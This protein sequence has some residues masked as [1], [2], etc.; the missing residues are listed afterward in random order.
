[1]KNGVFV[2]GTDTEVG[3][4]VVA[5]GLALVLKEAGVNVGVMKPVA[6]GC[7]E[8]GKT[9]ISP[10][11]VFLMEAAEN[12]FASLSSPYR[13]KESLAPSVA[14]ELENIEID[15]SRILFAYRELRKNY[16]IVE[17]AGGLFAPI[18][19]DFF[20][21]DLI[22][23]M[24]LSVIIVGR[25]GLGTINHTLLTIE[26]LKTRGIEIEGIIFNGLDPQKASFS[27]LSNPRLISS[28]TDVPLLGV[29]P[30]VDFLSVE[31]C[32]FGVLLETFKRN[33]A[34]HKLLEK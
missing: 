13:L 18:K 32:V 34:V 22:K 15:V 19:K 31:R 8:A 26:A 4:T 29:L 2:V 21:S 17:G 11:A 20:I 27:E 24:H 7:I 3:K 5:A 23:K 33:I 28:L 6:S 14:A 30:K 10:D 9:M 1:M 16:V 25:I 12:Q